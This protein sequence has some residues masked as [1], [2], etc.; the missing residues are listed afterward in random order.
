MA[1][2]QS[3]NPTLSGV[4]SG[5]SPRYANGIQLNMSPWDLVME[6]QEIS[7]TGTSAEGVPQLKV[8]VVMNCD[9]ASTR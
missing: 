5:D 6:F 3:L 9:V 2:W 8:D 4:E 7:V 1:E